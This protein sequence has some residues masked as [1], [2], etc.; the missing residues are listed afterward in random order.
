MAKGGG[1]GG[2]VLIILIGHDAITNCSLTKKHWW[3][4]LKTE[5]KKSLANSSH[6]GASAL[7]QKISG[8]S[9]NCTYYAEEC[10]RNCAN[11]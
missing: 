5:T 1:G 3:A 10:G 4:V 9:Q 7:Q 6:E 8:K 11:L 2:G